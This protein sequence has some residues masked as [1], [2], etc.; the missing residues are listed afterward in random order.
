ML[1]HVIVRWSPMRCTVLSLS[2]AIIVFAA[3][4]RAADSCF[5]TDNYTVTRG[6]PF[7]L[8]WEGDGSEHD[9]SLF[10]EGDESVGFIAR[11]LT[12]TS[13]L[14][15]PPLN[16]SDGPYKFGLFIIRRA[17]ICYSPI[18]TVQGGADVPP[19]EL[20]GPLA[21]SAVTINQ[22]R[23][24]VTA[25]VA[26]FTPQDT[27]SMASVSQAPS[28]A[29]SRPP[30]DDA[31][32]KAL[33]IGIPVTA[34]MLFLVLVVLGVLLWRSRRQR[35]QSRMLEAKLL[36][37]DGDDAASIPSHRTEPPPEDPMPELE[38][39]GNAAEMEGRAQLYAIEMGNESE[40]KA[41]MDSISCQTPVELP[42]DVPKEWLAG[43]RRRDSYVSALSGEG[44]LQ[45]LDP[46]TISPL[47]TV[48]H[49][50]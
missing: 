15:T 26:R 8:T 14:W 39:R 41:E 10:T 45:S 17:S 6:S 24:T 49:R 25:T 46:S 34:V 13:L 42:G 4:S 18:F 30:E 21:V 12:Q 32:K 2:F 44:T 16:I 7:I 31:G 50:S 33:Q 40:I 29:L 9:L 43:V 22:F 47:S 20:S 28:S 3:V 5:R 27:A 38:T 35:Q 36:S 1:F 11:N 48:K 37:T 19:L 23:T